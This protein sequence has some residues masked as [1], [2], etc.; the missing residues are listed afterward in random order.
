MANCAKKGTPT[1]GLRDTI[2][3]VILKS[4]PEN[5]TTN[6]KEKEIR[7]YFDEYIK[8]MDLQ[9]NL[10]IS[11]P[12]KYNPIITPL[13]TSKMLKITIL[14]TLLENTTY[15]FNFDKS[16]VD[17]NEDNAFDYFKYVLSTGSYIDSLTVTGRITDAVLPTA[18]YPVAVMLYEVNEEFND[19]MVFSKKPMYLAATRDSSNTFEITN[20]KEG[21]YLLLALKEKNNDY[22]FQPKNDKIGF[23]NE[24]IELPTD[25]AFTIPIFKELPDYSLAR[26]S[27]TSKFHIVFGYEGDGSE[28]ELEPISAMPEGFHSVSVRDTERDSLHYWFKPEIVTDSL[29]FLAKNKARTDT[30]EVRMKNLFPDSLAISAFKTGTFI[31]RDT[32]KLKSSIPLVQIDDAQIRIMDND[33]LAIAFETQL[34]TKNNLAEIHFQKKDDQRYKITLLP[35]ALTD[36]YESK[37]DSLQFVIKTLANSDYGTLNLTLRNIDSY[38]VIVELVTDKY[39]VSAR[40]IITQ[41]T[42]VYFDYIKPGN[43]FVRIIFDENANG[44]WDTGNFLRRIQ[45]EKIIFYPTK[46]EIRANWSLNETFTL[47]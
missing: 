37:S 21:K 25:S 45:P 20:V 41:N 29:L 26:P 9:K 43:Y 40:Q 5:Y 1:G 12:L 46:L 16:I 35:G 44:I 33:S 27:Q 23:V 31:P 3:P 42:P 22:T 18:E 8:L 24:F 15:S 4:V 14:D 32:V 2:P 28:L 39:Q 34:D 30:L 10:I 7:I 13:S 19:S 17:N 38:P 36:F 6:F 47:N 11:P